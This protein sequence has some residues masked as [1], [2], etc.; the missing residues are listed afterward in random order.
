MEFGKMDE[1]DLSVEIW[2]IQ[3]LY[4]VTNFVWADKLYL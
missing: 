2:A 1:L 4:M 3:L